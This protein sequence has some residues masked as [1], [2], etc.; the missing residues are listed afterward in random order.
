M[1]TTELLGKMGP[2]LAERMAAYKLTTHAV[3][4]TTPALN[5]LLA[6][7]A[8]THSPT[9]VRYM[10]APE[11]PRMDNNHFRWPKMAL[12][13]KPWF[14]PVH[15]KAKNMVGRTLKPSELPKPVK[16]ATVTSTHTHAPD[17]TLAAA[18][19]PAAPVPASAVRHDSATEVLEQQQAKKDDDYLAKEARDAAVDETQN[20]VIDAGVAGV[21][22][23]DHDAELH[24]VDLAEIVG[25]G[26]EAQGGAAPGAD[27][28]LSAEGVSTE[29]YGG[30]A[31]SLD[32]LFEQHVGETMV[33]IVDGMLNFE[34]IGGLF[35]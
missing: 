19:A 5:I 1:K 21:G 10:V 24:D 3:P 15:G 31:P 22:T 4:G 18:L 2:Y 9:S 28:D 26:G 27:Y 20:A 23:E 29:L 34:M 25:S 16:H 6:F 8:A 14:K 30:G 33:Q 12:P 17:P 11:F 13:P 32:D 7:L 35:E